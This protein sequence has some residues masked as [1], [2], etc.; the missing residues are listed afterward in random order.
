MNK[1][2]L[3]FSALAGAM[4]IGAAGCGSG[5]QTAEEKAAAS[6]LYEANRQKEVTE[7][8]AAFPASAPQM[9]ANLEAISTRDV[10]DMEVAASTIQAFDQ[11]ARNIA[12]IEDAAK[13]DAI[14]VSDQAIAAKDE[15]KRVL[16]RRQRE[17]FPAM[18][19]T[20][21]AYM[22]DAVAGMR[23][24][25]RAVGSGGKTLRGASPSFTSREVVMEAHYTLAGQANRFRFNKAEYVYSLTGASDV[26]KMHG[27]ADE[28]IR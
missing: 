23:A 1:L 22:S 21:A 20:Y 27:K 8:I 19:R 3:A 6:R 26:I 4:L 7:Q 25:F 28:D 16:I 10:S 18:R 2:N 12:I 17:L 24:N 14:P 15:L 5:E 11:A 9:I 13:E